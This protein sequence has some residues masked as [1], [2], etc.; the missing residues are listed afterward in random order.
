M[1]APRTTSRRRHGLA[2]LSTSR[3]SRGLMSRQV[4]PRVRRV[5]RQGPFDV[6][7]TATQHRPR[8]S[9]GAIAQRTHPVIAYAFATP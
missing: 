9:A 6:L 7:A 3:R 5:A 8:E 1:P 4:R 2:K